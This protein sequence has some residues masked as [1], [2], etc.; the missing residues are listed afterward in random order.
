MKEE[1]QDNYFKVIF[2]YDNGSTLLAQGEEYIHTC[3]KRS[4]QVEYDEDI[5]TELSKKYSITAILSIEKIKKDEYW[6]YIRNEER[7][8]NW[9]NI[10]KKIK[11]LKEL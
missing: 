10:L 6:E 3:V 9:R 8:N 11:R 5:I 4:L 1:L 2:Y 7:H